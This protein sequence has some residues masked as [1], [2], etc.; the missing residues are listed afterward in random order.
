MVVMP[1][2]PKFLY[3]QKKYYQVRLIIKSVQTFDGVEIHNEIIF[4]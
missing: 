4:Y 3:I 1:E 2:S